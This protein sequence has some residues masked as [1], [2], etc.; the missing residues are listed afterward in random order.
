MADFTD[1]TPEE[2]LRLEYYIR[3]QR[4]SKEMSEAWMREEFLRWAKQALGWVL[5]KIEYAWKWLRTT[6]GL[7]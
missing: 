6:L 3:Q 1:L 5:D 2:L 7:D 4:R